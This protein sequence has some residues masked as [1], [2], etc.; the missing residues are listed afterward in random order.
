M[1][2][3]AGQK[4]VPDAWLR[5]LPVPVTDLDNQ[6]T[7]ADFLDVETA[8]IDSV[9]AK[10]R[11]MLDVL[12]EARLRALE[13]AFSRAGVI[14]PAGVDREAL[15]G[16][17]LPPGWRL[18]RLGT[19]LLQLTNGYVGPTRDI[20]RDE[21][22]R[23]IQ[24]LHL[25]RSA[26]DFARRPFFVDKDWHDARPRTA[27]RPGDVLIVQTGDIGQ[28]AVVPEGF[29]EANCHALLIAR[30]NPALITPAY[31]GA[32]LQSLFG[33]QALLRLATGALHPHLEFG[34]RDALLLVP[35][36][37]VQATLVAEVN[38]R[39]A[40]I[41]S[42]AA[43]LSLQVELLREHRQTLITAAVMGEIEIQGTAA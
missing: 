30:V 8:R 10:K 32:Y 22:V 13:A 19:T 7:I 35:T 18:L 23:Y 27:L 11:R 24:G 41:D 37:E 25:K 39:V 31:L 4:R 33:R 38:Q 6:R 1:I 9:V 17:V 20:L 29:G 21:G 42:A 43:K 3:V 36:L 40:R 2:G 28:C 34:I 5:D 14:L 26:I 12:N 15:V 16:H